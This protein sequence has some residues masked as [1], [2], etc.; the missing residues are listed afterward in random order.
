M[1]S[2]SSVSVLPGLT[3]LQESPL[4]DI[5]KLLQDVR[6]YWY[7]TQ[8]PVPVNQRGRA[9]AVLGYFHERLRAAY[10]DYAFWDVIPLFEFFCLARILPYMSEESEKRC[11]LS[12]MARV[13]DSLF[14]SPASSPTGPEA[15]TVPADL[16]ESYDMTSKTVTVIVPALGQDMEA[17]FPS[18]EVKLL[19]VN[20][21]SRFLST[22]LSRYPKD[23]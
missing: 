10:V 21:S 20:V 7:L 5:A 3:C 12:G 4:Q 13:H 23:D 8:V 2:S 17:M 11:V 14:S 22:F 15:I 9:V 16:D 1:S 18:G 19:T 6:H